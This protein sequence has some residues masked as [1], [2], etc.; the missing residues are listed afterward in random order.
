MFAD[1][2]TTLTSRVAKERSVYQINAPT[3]ESAAHWSLWP[4][5]MFL[6]P[7]KGDVFLNPPIA[8]PLERGKERVA[9]V[10]PADGPDRFVKRAHPTTAP[11]RLS[12]VSNGSDRGAHP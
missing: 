1:S 9:A 10:R 3:Q 11:S 6:V 7:A 2:I 8:A 12:I 4:G 5:P